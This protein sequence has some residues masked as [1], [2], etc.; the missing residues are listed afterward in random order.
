[1]VNM[2]RSNA[3]RFNPQPTL[4][5][6]M[7]SDYYG[8]YQT[9][10]VNNQAFSCDTFEITTRYVNESRQD[11]SVITGTGLVIDLPKRNCTTDRLVICVKV[12]WG[13]K[14]QV[15]IPAILKHWPGLTDEYLK[16]LL[17]SVTGSNSN[18]IKSLEFYYTIDLENIEQDPY[19]IWIEHLNVQVV[20]PRYSTTTT[21]FTRDCF[22]NN[23]DDRYEAEDIIWGSVV[24]SL[25]VVNDPEN[26]NPVY[27][28]YATDLLELTPVC[29]YG[30]EEG[31]HLNLR[32]KAGFAARRENTKGYVISIEE[33]KQHGIISSVREWREQIKNANKGLTKAEFDAMM[34]TFERHH[35]WLMGER[36]PPLALKDLVLFGDVTIGNASDLILELAK[37]NQAIDKI[38]KTK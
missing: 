33:F 35:G 28:P 38:F 14:A 36:T 4:E 37:L 9:E 29:L 12:R 16:R 21:F 32:G 30:V 31:I 3:L 27:I 24:S 22:Y 19:G 7:I 20:H 2:N 11:V 15:N 6:P 5:A 26:T 17:Q 25:Y 34:R 1:M 10:S 23:N 18:N 13:Y 8:R